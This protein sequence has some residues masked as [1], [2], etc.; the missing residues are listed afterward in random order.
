MHTHVS[1]IGVVV[2]RNFLIPLSMVGLG[3]KIRPGEATS[4]GD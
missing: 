1:C 2:I 4:E 3:C